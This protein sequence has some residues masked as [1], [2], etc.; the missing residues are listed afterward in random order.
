M[1]IYHGLFHEPAHETTSRLFFKNLHCDLAHFNIDLL[2]SFD[3]IINTV[4]LES[5]MKLTFATTGFE[6]IHPIFFRQGKIVTSNR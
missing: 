4:A 3:R 1:F 5:E 6:N 2:N